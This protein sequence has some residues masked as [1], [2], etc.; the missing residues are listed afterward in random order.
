[1]GARPPFHAVGATFVGVLLAAGTASAQVDRAV[2]LTSSQSSTTVGRQ[3]TLTLGVA[4]LNATLTANGVVGTVDLPSDASPFSVP[5]GCVFA[6]PTVT[7]SFGSLVP[8]GS[9]SVAIVV[10]M[11]GSGL[12]PFKAAVTGTEID[13]NPGNDT[14]GAKVTVLAAFD[15][16]VVFFTVRSDDQR[17]YLEWINPPDPYRATQIHRT[18]SEGDCNSN[19]GVFETNPNNLG[20]RIAIQGAAGP[21]AHDT[22][23]DGPLP[24]LVI[25]YCYTLFV[26][27][28]T[29][30]S[31]GY[32]NSGRP[33]T[34]PVLWSFDTNSTVMPP[35]ALNSNGY[36]IADDSLYAFTLGTGGGAWPAGWTPFRYA[37]GPPSLQRVTVTGAPIGSISRVVLAGM[38]LSGNS[39][40]GRVYATDGKTG[41]PIWQSDP[42]GGDT[43]VQAGISGILSAFSGASAPDALLVGTVN[44]VKAN[45]FVGL[46]FKT[47]VQVPR[48]T[49]TN[50]VGQGGDGTQMGVVA[51]QAAIDTTKLRAYFGSRAFGPA[52]DR[53]LWAVDFSSGDA[54]LVWLKK[55]AE[56]WDTDCGP[57]LRDTSVYVGDKKGS[58]TALEA[59][60]G[61]VRWAFSTGAV[62][63]EVKG[64]VWP[65]RGDKRLYFSTESRLWALDDPGGNTPPGAATWFLDYLPIVVSPPLVL[66]DY[67]YFGTSDGRLHQVDAARNERSLVLGSGLSAIGT[68]TGDSQNSLVYVG[69]A[70]GHIYAVK[71]PF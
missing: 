50:D 17:N 57:S 41:Q 35:P 4:N 59:D 10:T 5:G 61:N 43:S 18:T 26:D 71:V 21:N 51:A 36:A 24:N 20:T 3:I 30:F 34:A 13:T 67:A 70:D 27:D 31:A 16:R 63:G 11:N 52:D 6:S 19:P 2:S 46:D 32:N 15:G 55:Q 28:G 45:S 23:V 66:N 65:V 7:C 33:I 58:V 8:L 42:L 44:S 56:V 25:D 48:F 22:F 38:G 29:T 37:P 60:T 53:T 12:L 54:K 14:G 47:G 64:L 68:P 39:T 69:S 49:Y 9:T 62:D 40:S 1:M